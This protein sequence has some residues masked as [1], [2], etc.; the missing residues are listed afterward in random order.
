MTPNEVWSVITGTAL[1]IG[2][3]ET[4]VR[5]IV[6]SKLAVHDQRVTTVENKQDRFAES[7]DRLG[8]TILELARS[9]GRLEGQKEGE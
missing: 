2:W 3:I 8:D 4:R 6:G 7:I 9:V 1:V 5:S